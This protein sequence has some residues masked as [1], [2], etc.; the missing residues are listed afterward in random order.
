M[1]YSDVTDK[2]RFYGESQE[3]MKKYCSDVR[4]SDRQLEVIRH[5]VQAGVDV[6]AYAHPDIPPSIM[7]T[8]LI[9]MRE[10]KMF[11]IRYTRDGGETV[12]VSAYVG[13]TKQEALDKFG[14]DYKG[15]EVVDVR[16]EGGDNF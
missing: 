8:I 10:R 9:H 2:E 6:S 3:G 12:S 16:E 13:S 11:H 15:V 14:K 7:M 5:G 1:K 4:F